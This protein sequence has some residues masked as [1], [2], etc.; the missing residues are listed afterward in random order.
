MSKMLCYTIVLAISILFIFMGC[1]NSVDPPEGNDT[2][3]GEIAFVSDRDGNLAIYIMNADGTNPRRF[4][5]KNPEFCMSPSWSPDNSK[6][7]Y[8]AMS[9][10]E[11]HVYITD[12]WIKSVNGSEDVHVNEIIPDPLLLAYST[13]KW[14][15]DGTRLALAA[16]SENEKENQRCTI[17]LVPPDGSTIDESIPLP[18]EIFFV[19]W[20]PAGNELL[21]KNIDSDQAPSG[22]IYKLDIS[23]RELTEVCTGAF[24][25]NW[26]PDG[27]EIVFSSYLTQSVSIINENGNVR[28]LTHFEDKYPNMVVW[29]PDGAHIVV[30][31][32]PSFDRQHPSNLYLVD[33][34][35]GEV[36]TVTEGEHQIGEL[37]WSPDGKYLLF[38]A[39]QNQYTSQGWPLAILWVYNLSS[40]EKKK[41]TSGN[42]L[43]GNGNWS[44]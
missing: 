36:T 26:S 4:A 11:P 28:E 39:T 22:S 43:D 29:S 41:L 27:I 34:N 8:L 15:P 16:Q 14:S 24:G 20:S 13:P 44:N 3:E 42:R 32:S 40:G 12:V 19:L 6:I 38:T 37:D 23:S 5:W 10:P 18:W 1:G 21:L 33:S 31:T 9:S 30:A 25:A 35:T 7:A 2:A 17:Y